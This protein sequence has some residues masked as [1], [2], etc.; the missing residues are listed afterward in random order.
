M[1]EKK[2]TP[3]QAS[4]NP[5]PPSPQPPASSPAPQTP[6]HKQPDNQGKPQDKKPDSPP[7]PQNGGK[8]AQSAPSAGKPDKP[9]ERK[10]AAPAPTSKAAD[11]PPPVQRPLAAESGKRGNGLSLLALAI[12]AIALA[13]GG[14]QFLQNAK[15]ASQLN[16]QRA[17][18][19]KEISRLDEAAKQNGE[20]LATLQKNVADI[21]IP[22]PGMDRDS[23]MKAIAEHGEQ[24]D[25]TLNAT[26]DTR[27]A[28][29]PD[30]LSRE[31]VQ[32]QIKQALATFAQGSQP[33]LDF[34]DEI[35]KVQASE[36]NAK[37]ILAQIEQ[38]AAQL[39]SHL[40][41][42]L[43][44]AEKQLGEI[45]DSRASLL[46]LLSLAQLAGH[47]GQYQSAAQY[48][49]QAGKLLSGSDHADWQG[50]VAEA[51]RQYKQLS[52][53][54]APSA[55]LNTLIDRVEAW[56]LRD[57]GQENLLADNATTKPQ[58]F[59]DKVRQAG[60]DIL[61]S[62]VTVTPLDDEGLAWINHN[63][64]LQNII[65]QNVRL[66]LAF[67]RNA[68]QMQDKAAFTHIAA[69]LKSA[70][71]RYFDTGNAEVQAALEALAALDGAQTDLPDLASMIQTLRS[72]P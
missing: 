37:Q 60:N 12:S 56:P 47:A 41:Q 58:T 2:N 48:L 27:F 57:S 63:P 4:N 71:E 42:A 14:Y 59:M 6:P 46:N 52:V 67:A 23:V 69:T 7:L 5:K 54:P 53:L 32:S 31:D 34:S 36:A 24:L 35:A 66:D 51:A 72:A 21:R 45:A 18:T 64:A 10:P 39:D 15:L 13:L 19:S 49:E 22:A 11:N 25:K 8:S 61:A 55:T 33:T 30:P 44:A 68:L 28:T 29:L 1:S 43:A 16:D 26:L 17:V 38:N 62:T 50:A 9:E 20:Q 3:P 40:Q 65:R 70:I